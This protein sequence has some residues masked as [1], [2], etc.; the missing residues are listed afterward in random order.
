MSRKTL[1]QIMKQ[2]SFTGADVGKAT[3]LT[4]VDHFLGKKAALSDNDLSLMVKTIV[5]PT[6]AAICKAYTTFGLYLESFN[7]IQLGNYQKFYHGLDHL[8]LI[9]F[10]V[11]HNARKYLDYLD[12]PLILSEEEY[13]TYREKAKKAYYSRKFTLEELIMELLYGAVE[14]SK[15]DIPL[16][17]AFKELEPVFAK[18]NEELVNDQI[19]TLIQDRDKKELISQYAKLYHVNNDMRTLFTFITNK[20]ATDKNGEKRLTQEEIDHLLEL[21]P[22]D[23]EQAEGELVSLIVED[24]RQETNNHRLE[25]F[26]KNYLE[27]IEGQA[28]EWKIGEDSGDTSDL[29]YTTTEGKQSRLWKLGDQLAQEKTSLQAIRKEYPEL[30]A[31]ID[32]LEN[33]LTKG[34]RS[35]NAKFT[36]EDVAPLGIDPDYLLD[37][38]EEIEELLTAPMDKPKCSQKDYIRS[39]KAIKGIAIAPKGTLAPLIP[40]WALDFDI[41]EEPSRNRDINILEDFTDDINS[42]CIEDLVKPAVIGLYGFNELL[43]IYGN[44]LKVDLSPLKIDMKHLKEKVESYNNLL[45]ITTALLTDAPEGN[46]VVEKN[47]QKIKALF[48]PIDIETMRPDPERIAELEKELEDLPIDMCIDPKYFDPFF[49]GGNVIIGK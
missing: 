45:Y 10:N 44:R 49:E 4:L 38:N 39:M 28:V 42:S 8:L 31:T 7:S 36:M 40:K 22:T 41:T 34:K 37:L 46:P 13:N 21:I 16:G 26:K 27:Q 5:N 35:S 48:K 17:P 43:D 33:G 19:L 1:N 15:E 2:T 25:N 30:A 18:Y 6:Q 3:L 47:K 20:L 23:P 29:L 24:A 32:K 9:L 14:R 11:Y 12:T